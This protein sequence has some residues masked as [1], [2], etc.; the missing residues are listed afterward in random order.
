MVASEPWDCLIVGGGPAGLTAARYLARYRRRVIVIDGG[1]SRARAIPQSHNHPGF[2]GISGAG[3]LARL[4]EEAASYGVPIRQGKVQQIAKTAAGFV[5]TVCGEDLSANTVLMA[6]GVTDIGP[7]LAYGD[8]AVAESLV[9]FCPICDGYEAMDRQIAVL[10]PI[11]EATTKALFLRTYSKCV[12]VLP[13]DGD[14]GGDGRLLCE[15]AIELLPPITALHRT[16]A[17][18]AASF[19]NGDN[20]TFDVVYPVLGCNVHS[21]LARKLAARCT[22]AGLIEV[23]SKQSTSVVGLYAAGD[24]VSDLHQLS[25]AEG[26]AAVAAT[27]IHN[28]LPRNPR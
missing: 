27:A 16:A 25:V 8:E 13:T 24:V 22:G 14:V 3:L 6:T 10:G 17:G 1:A 7:E 9:R 2:L 20:R 5:A 15:A 19:A 28:S 18:V 26:H 21:E 23:D 11:R 4:A 12:A